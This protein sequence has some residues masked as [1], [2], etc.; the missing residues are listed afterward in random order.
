[1]S[2]LRH[3]Y[4]QFAA[5]LIGL[6]APSQLAARNRPRMEGRNAQQALQADPSNV[7]ARARYAQALSEQGACRLTL[8]QL[9]ILRQSPDGWDSQTAT[10]EGTCWLRLGHFSLAETALDEAIFLDSGNAIARL[11]RAELSIMQ[12]DWANVEEQQSALALLKQTDRILWM[13][14]L[15][16]LLATGEGDLQAE[17][18]MF[19]ES[20]NSSGA[21]RASKVGIIYD[22]RGWL[23]D[24]HP[25]AAV[26][27]F[28]DVLNQNINLWQASLYRI[29]AYRRAGQQQKAQEILERS[30]IL[31]IDW[32]IKDA[33]AARVL[34]DLGRLDDA[35]ALMD[36]LEMS[37][38]LEVI[39]SR[40]Y[41]A[42]ARGDVDAM[43]YHAALW[44]T[45]NLAPGRSL[46]D[47]LPTA[48]GETP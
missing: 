9:D 23:R 26:D 41:L 12:G 14:S 15:E 33:F 29:E 19:R 34:V 38:L 48:S 35:A 27:V 7:Q 4:A 18:L 8:D 5:L 13:L 39:E 1:M 44:E 40:W 24:G 28:G 16:T 43:G 25:E 11:R 42:H 17:T 45:R 47:L 36:G 2:F 21:T 32:A 46:N 22:G 3:G 30:L 20:A 37:S 10:L 31:R 6:L